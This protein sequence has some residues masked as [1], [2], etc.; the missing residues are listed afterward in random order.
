MIYATTVHC[1]PA[2]RITDRRERETSLKSWHFTSI[3]LVG[4]GRCFGSLVLYGRLWWDWRIWRFEEN[5][6]YWNTK[7]RTSRSGWA[8]SVKGKGGTE[9][10]KG[11]GPE[12]PHETNVS[13]AL[14]GMDYGIVY[15]RFVVTLS[16]ALV[17]MDYGTVCFGFVVRIDRSARRPLLYTDF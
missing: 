3:K 2:T 13:Y 10:R 16:Y 9:V 6:N 11:S 7:Q 15:V 12:N 4:K 8:R 17:G 5:P 14:V 1:T